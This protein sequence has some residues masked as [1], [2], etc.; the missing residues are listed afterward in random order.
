MKNVNL[1]SRA[2]TKFPR[3]KIKLLMGL[4]QF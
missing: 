1:T 4:I 2:F 3:L